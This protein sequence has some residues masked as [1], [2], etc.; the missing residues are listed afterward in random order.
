MQQ[1]TLTDPTWTRGDAAAES[2]SERAAL[3]FINDVRDVPFLKL[4]AIL[5][6]TIVPSAVWQYVGGFV[7]WHVAVHMVLVFWFLGP[8]ILMLHNTSHRRFFKTKWGKLNHYIPWMLGPFFGETPETYFAHHIGMHHPENNL[9]DDLSTTL[10]YVRDSVWG[11]TRYFAKFF[12]TAIFDLPRYFVARNRRALVWKS[13]VGE[14]VFFVMCGGL[15]FLNWKATLVV[16][17]VPYLSTRLLMMCGNWGQHAFVDQKAPGDSYL[18]SITCINTGYNRRCF[19]D[20]YHIGHHVKQ[21]RHWTEMPDDFTAQR[22][23]YAE[24]GAIVFEGI[25]FFIVWVFLMLKRYNWL[26]RCYVHLGEGER[27]SEADIIALLR[28]RTQWTNAAA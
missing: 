5:N 1:I 4:I 15:A 14:V 10:P 21:T 9:E 23:I 13:F 19:N 3:T 22:G 6:L 27:P 18:N 26:A 20:G 16:F 12:F 11:F 28:S 24:K 8:Y 17:I 25:D 2:W 7:W